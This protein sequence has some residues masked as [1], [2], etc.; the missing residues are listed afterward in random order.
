LLPRRRCNWSGRCSKRAA[1]ARARFGYA[2]G[3]KNFSVIVLSAALSLGGLLKVASGQPASVDEQV[4]GLLSPPGSAKA[5]V[6][7]AHSYQSSGNRTIQILRIGAGETGEKKPAILLV[8]G[9]DARHR[10]GPEMALRVARKLVEA[11]PEWLKGVNVYVLPM[12]NPDAFAAIAGGSAV[13]FGRL[14]IPSGGTAV[15]DADRDRR[16]GED[17]AEDLNGDGMITLMR[18]KN[19]GPG[20]GLTATLIDE[21]DAEANSPWKGLM[22]GPDAAKGERAV[23]AVLA[24]GIDNDGDGKYNEDGPGPAGFGAGGGLDVD[25]NFPI[26][27]PEFEDGAGERPLQTPESRELVQWCLSTPELATVVVFGLH[28]TVIGIPEAGKFDATGQVPMGILNE[29]KG[30]YEAVSAK[31]RE[32]TG[33]NGAERPGLSGSFTAWAYAA[34][35]LPTFETPVWV[36][37]DRMDEDRRPKPAPAA[38]DA[39]GEKKEDAKEEKKEEPRPEP[40]TEDQRWMRALEKDAP[41]IAWK[42]FD[43]PTLGPVEIGGFAPGSKIDPAPGPDSDGRLERLAE[44]HT[45]FLGE[46]AG[47]FASVEAEASAERLGPGMWKIRAR[48]TNTAAWPTQTAMSVRTRQALPTSVTIGLAP[49]AIVSGNVRQSSDKLA[50]RGGRMDAEWVVLVKDG[51]TVKLTLTNPQRGPREI[52][53]ELSAAK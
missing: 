28:D 35:G 2:R 44:D 36:R 39:S 5:S 27:W 14:P 25:R 24:E 29:D 4:R 22:R 26:D 42:P 41:F 48:V 49:E 6:T 38:E 11:P 32:L 19:P 18:V 3:V 46:L 23:W 45:K 12:A 16:Q 15:N 52:K 21:S 34:L 50:P 37:V 8:A 1:A 40:K 17:P 31:Y 30:L 43:H 10:V 47:N 51:E 20:T 53:V 13:E 33:I 9:L 7:V